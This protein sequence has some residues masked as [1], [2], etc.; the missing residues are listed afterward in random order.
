MALPNPTN[1]TTDA[2]TRRSN[3]SVGTI[4]TRVD[5]DC[6]PKKA[7]LNNTMA[8]ST[9]TRVTKMIT[10]IIAALRPSASLRDRL[11][12]RPLRI[13]QLENQPPVRLPM[14][15]ARR[16]PGVVADLFHVESARVVEI[17]R[18]PRDVEEPGASVRNFAPTSPDLAQPQ[19]A[20]PPAPLFAGLA[21][22]DPQGSA[23]ARDHQIVHNKPA[24][25]GDEH[26][27]RANSMEQNGRDGRRRRDAPTAVPALTIPIAVER[28]L[29]GNHSAMTL[30]AAG[31]PPF[32]GA[33]QEPAAGEHPHAGG[34]LVAGARERPE[35][36]DDEKARAACRGDR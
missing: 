32:A 9:G 8:H 35:H 5:H 7:M 12:E 2:T 21:S 31:N 25:A 19:Q 33:E 27:A 10:G 18:Q 16:A 29:T 15:D 13:N 11:T 20:C 6:W 24:A 36:H 34:E 26:P 28:S 17:L 1:P 30:V 22:C 4:M 23:Y 3:R 14:P